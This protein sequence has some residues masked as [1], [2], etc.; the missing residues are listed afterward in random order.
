MGQMIANQPAVNDIMG[1]QSQRIVILIVRALECRGRA[2][3]DLHSDDGGVPNLTPDA[4]HRAGHVRCMDTA[5]QHS[6]SA[7]HQHPIDAD[8][9]EAATCSGA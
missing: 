9:P 2:Q 1:R 5:V 3:H 6:C 4:G 7:T 8:L